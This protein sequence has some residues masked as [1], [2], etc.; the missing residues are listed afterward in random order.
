MRR[1]TTRSVVTVYAFV[2]LANVSLAGE[3]TS[4]QEISI[5]KSARLK[6]KFNV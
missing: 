6:Q 2:V 3:A 4:G 5:G 1:G